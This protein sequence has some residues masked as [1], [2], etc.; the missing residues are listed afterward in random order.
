MTD[1]ASLYPVREEP[2]QPFDSWNEHEAQM[3][4]ASEGLRLTGEHWEVIYFLRNFCERHGSK[5]QAHKVLKP[6]ADRFA[7]RGGKKYLY[8]LFPGGPIAQACR[9]AGLPLP[10]NTLD[11]GFGSVH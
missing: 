7:D 8:S 6:L 10:R 3:I 11:P 2:S 1:I 9:I 4:A 5:C